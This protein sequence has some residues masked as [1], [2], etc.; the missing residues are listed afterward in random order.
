MFKRNDTRFHYLRFIEGGEGGGSDLAAADGAD[1]IEETSVDEDA[2]EEK[3]W[4]AEYEAQQRI[5]RSLERR[6]K[7]DLATI[8]GLQGAAPAAAGDAPD[9]DAIRAE[10]RAELSTAN[11]ARLV[12]LEAKAALV[13]KV[14]NPA[15]TLRLLD[16]SEVEVD[17]AGNV[18][19]QAL[20]DQI[21]KLL[22]D[23]PYLAV[24]QG[25]GQQ[26]FQGK[27]DQG[28]QGAAKSMEQQ[29]SED[30][31]DATQKRD[32]PRAISIK[33]RIAALAKTK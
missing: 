8:Q 17:E 11:N 20:D 22:E 33:Q 13:G 15:T 6:S 30:L 2:T 7:K 24:A 26:R 12:S 19:I 27:A 10:I 25:A 31:A 4:K 16:L 23:E 29:L 28:P 14:H 18:D 1:I 3:D 21:L 9:A 32:F 5:N